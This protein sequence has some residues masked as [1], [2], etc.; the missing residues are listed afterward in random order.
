MASISIVKI[1]IRRG[2]DSE[3]RRIVLDN[4]E[5]GYVTDPGGR[6]LFIGDGVRMGG[7]PTSVSFFYNADLTAPLTYQ[8]ALV[9]DILYDNSSS[10]LYTITNINDSTSPAIYTFKFIGAATDEASIQYNLA[11]N[12]TVNLSGVN[13][14]TLPTSNPGVGTK[15]LWNDGGYVRVS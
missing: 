12:L 10:K 13:G 1:K 11:G 9:G 2:T 3:R 7:Y 4:G 14:N 8:Y 6:R 15:K 5:L